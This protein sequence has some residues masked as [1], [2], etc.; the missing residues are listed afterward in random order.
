MQGDEHNK[1]E[2]FRFRK[3]IN[4]SRNLVIEIIFALFA[5]QFVQNNRNGNIYA[6]LSMPINFDQVE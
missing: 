2:L 4:Y 3:I 5:E 6:H 1:Y